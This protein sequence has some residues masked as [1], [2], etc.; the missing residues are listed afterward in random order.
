MLQLNS[1]PRNVYGLDVGLGYYNDEVELETD[2]NVKESTFSAYAAWT[3]ESPE[4][5][6][7]Y[8]HS[9]HESVIDSSDSGDVNAWYAQFAY[10]LK[11]KHDQWK[12]YVRFENQDIDSTDPLLGS[13]G[14]DQE[15]SILGVRWD[16]NPY[17]ALKAEYRN[18]EFN[19]GGRENNFRLQISF[20]LAKL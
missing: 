3:K 6:I 7:E 10:R 12:P 8:L 17:A 9:N 15:A 19:N 18:E 1:R 4:V 11:G 5:I 20:V 13:E 2:P 16:F 14:L